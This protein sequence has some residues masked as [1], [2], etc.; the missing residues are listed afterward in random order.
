MKSCEF[1]KLL[2]LARLQKNMTQEKL[3]SELSVT[4][5]AISKWETGKNLPDLEMIPQIS[6]VLSIPIDNLYHPERMIDYFE[7]NILVNSD[8]LITNETNKQV[9]VNKDQTQFLEKS[10]DTKFHPRICV[11]KIVVVLLTLVLIIAGIAQYIHIRNDKEL[12]ITQVAF[13]IAND[14]QCGEVYEVACVC[15]VDLEEMNLSSPYVAL[16]A[17]DWEN[18]SSVQSNIAIMKVSFYETELQARQ[19]EEPEKSIYLIR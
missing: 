8:E 19:W 11:K 5:S 4:V 1:G 17:S 9:L 14:E 6:R 2:R 15:N 13:R 3:A 12:R 16:L 7:K 10:P 18:D